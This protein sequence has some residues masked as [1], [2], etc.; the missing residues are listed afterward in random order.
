MFHVP[1]QSTNNGTS[2][3]TVLRAFQEKTVK[4]YQLDQDDQLVCV[5]YGHETNFYHEA[6]SVSDI[7]QLGA[8]VTRL[9]ALD[10]SILIRGQAMDGLGA[11]VRR[12]SDNF[13]EVDPGCSWLML[14]FDNL[15]LPDGMDELSVEAIEYA[16]TKLP[17]EFLNTTYFYQFS[18]SAGITKPDGSPLKTGLNAHLFFYLS[19]PVQGKRVAAY[20]SLYCL[21]CG[22]YE[23]TTNRSGAPMIRLGIDPAVLRSSVQP[24]YVG[25]PILGA[26][27]RCGLSITARQGSVNKAR[28][29][30]AL[31]VMAD[32]IES[33]A[34]VEHVKILTEHKRALGFVQAKAV[35]RAYDGSIGTT[36]YYR[37]NSGVAPSAAKMFTG[38]R[39]YNETSF[40]LFFEGES[41]PGSWYVQKAS[42]TLARRFGGGDKVPLKELSDSAYAYVR[43]ELHWFQEVPQNDA[44][45]LTAEGFL[46]DIS[47]F[48]L[49]RNC[50]IEAPTGSGKT[51]AF[52]RYAA[53][54]RGEIIFYAAQTKALVS[55]MATDLRAHQIRVTHYRDFRS[56][57]ELL[58]GVYVTTNE[59]LRKL[60]TRANVLGR[61]YILVIDEAHM[62]LDDFMSKASKNIILEQ[63]IARARKTL[64]MTATISNV[65]TA[66]W[67]GVISSACGELRPEVF[68][69]YKFTPVKRSTLILR[70]ISAFGSELV[71][72][73]KHYQALKAA[74]TALPRT[75][76]IAPTSRMRVFEALLDSFGLKDES[77]VVSRQESSDVDVD[78]A[79]VSTKPILISSPMFALGLNFEAQPER[80]WTYFSYMQ[81]DASQIVQTLNRANRG[82]VRAEV[83][84]YHG[85]LDDKPIYLP[86]SVREAARVRGILEDEATLQGALNEHLHIERPVYNAMRKAE[87]STAKALCQL[88]NNDAIQ[89]Y[90]IDRSWT[91]F[92][93]ATDEDHGIFKAAMAGARQSYG[94]DVSELASHLNDE[95]APLLLHR[96]AAL[97]DEEQLSGSTGSRVAR[98]LETE[99]LATISA[100]CGTQD[101]SEAKQ[102]KPARIRRLFGELPP[103]VTAQFASGPPSLMRKVQAEKTMALIPLLKELQKLR[104]GKKDGV[105]FAHAMRRA[106]RQAVT[107]LADSEADFLH[108]WGRKLARLDELADEYRERASSKRRKEIQAEQFSIAKQF[109]ETIGV[110]FD[111]PD[112]SSMLDASFPRLPDWN[113]ERMAANLDVRAK[114]LLAL[115]DITLPKDQVALTW[116]DSSVSRDVCATCAH[117]L[118]AWECA[119]GIPVFW[120]EQDLTDP[121]LSCEKKASLPAR[122][123]PRREV[124]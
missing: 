15:A 85:D 54:N 93:E 43:D 14:D 59:S 114:S 115:P 24:H 61:G 88:I 120:P 8:L 124:H 121:V 87:Q 53:A 65:Q 122:M 80:F 91:D 60:T 66:K 74:G 92:L 64:L 78:L 18:A 108:V 35:T 106:L 82:T 2:T 22:F 76:I 70:P 79:R 39:P 10:D 77:D 63:A 56:D 28:P 42:P 47:T 95:P 96:L 89:N 116:R 21:R 86:S 107:A 101:I 26:G 123:W 44:L 17:P 23:R 9:S 46:P 48:A 75:V 109:L 111:K 1:P 12:R 57:D 29:T 13:P 94:E 73:L 104:E 71:A 7:E 112:A 52:S 37:P 84:L 3:V 33:K 97:K 31:P 68:S 16:V 83:R 99:T 117:R 90:R 103:L 113:L 81:V 41:S 118:P 30:V 11:P 119:L 6:V 19:Q 72:L 105:A 25:L 69:M 62:A 98:Q 58:P 55:Q 32:D 27:V 110:N 34:S 38:G 50:L 36:T 100:L 20:L 102:V 49:A 45:A 67:A 4:T 51:T 5:P 40:I